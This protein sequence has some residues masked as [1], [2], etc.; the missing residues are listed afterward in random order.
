MTSMSR[1]A[2]AFAIA[3]AI[4]CA[5]PDSPP[6]AR[7]FATPDAAVH[8]LIGIVKQKN[9]DELLALLGP[10]GEQLAASSD[11]ATGRRHR[12]V[13]SAAVA[14]GWHLVEHGPDRRSLVVGNENWPFPIPLVRE[15]DG[16]RFDTAAGKE[17]V[18]A[19]RV[20]RNELAVIQICRTYVAAQQLYSRQ[21]HD[22]KPPGLYAKVFQSDAGKQ[23]GL[24]WPAG[25]DGKRSPLG[26]LVAEAA[27]DG[28]TTRPAGERP[29]PFH[30]YYFKILTAQGSHAPGGAK[31][32]VRNGELS[33]GFALIA[34]PADYDDTGVMTFI[35]N[36]DGM[37]FESDLG[38]DTA[39]L[40][41]QTTRYDPD[42]SWSI[43]R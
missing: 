6:K 29:M 38:P 22:G 17:E 36:R 21:G 42:P 13:F 11:P 7:A 32:Y 34:W 19:R 31:D 28:R 5:A 3:T 18:I 16:W 43:V 23:N 2:L 15:A 35:V 4:A 14:E 10:D 26:E 8:A 40:A 1:G 9:L 12:E 27:A 25:R 30:G 41:S 37:V 33:D 24:Y 39:S 20:G